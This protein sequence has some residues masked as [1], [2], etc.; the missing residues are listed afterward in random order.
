MKNNVSNHGV[1]VNKA[2]FET[3]KA[4]ADT[5]K[6]LSAPVQLIVQETRVGYHTVAVVS[7]G[8][9]LKIY[10]LDEKGDLRSFLDSCLLIKREV[11][12]S[13]TNKPL[14]HVASSLL[15]LSAGIK[16]AKPRAS[17]LAK[18]KRLIPRLQTISA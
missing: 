12:S 7:A 5:A 13:L 9:V 16:P 2:A 17:L 6:V 3:V 14:G 4:L 10:H 15:E 11:I 1:S 8:E 18:F